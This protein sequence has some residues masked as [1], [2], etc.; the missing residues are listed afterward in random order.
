MNV[1]ASQ[2]KELREKTGAG[3]MDC[4]RALAESDGDVEK[5]VDVLRK[6]GVVKSAKLG[7]RVV[8]QGAVFAY[9]HPGSQIGVLVEVDCETDF[10]ARTADFQALGKN[11]AMQVAAASP[12]YVSRED[13][14]ADLVERERE[15]LRSQAKAEGK[16]DRIIEK[17]V[18]GRLD[19]FYQEQCLLDQPYIRDD[20][21]KVKDL[22]T[23]A[24]AKIGENVVVRRFARFQI[25]TK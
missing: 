2:V 25:G 7:S 19:K 24:M 9:V 1:S 4:K 6:Q 12:V 17:M 8:S 16:P 22:V 5:A 14:P 15:V 3:M 18:E 11:L 21:R 10:V 20:A 13:V 23:D